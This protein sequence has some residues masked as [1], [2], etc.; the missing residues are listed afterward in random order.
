MKKF[1]ATLTLRNMIET[2]CRIISESFT[3]QGWRKPE[4]QYR[5]YL[6]QQKSSIRDVLIAEKEGQFCGYLTI[7]W[8]SDYPFFKEKGI[9]EIQDFNV[10]QHYQ[11]HGIG[12]ALMNEAEKRIKKISKYAGIGFGLTKDYGAAQILY[13]KRRYV[14]DGKGLVSH[15]KYA[16][17]GENVPV[18]DDLALY[19]IKQL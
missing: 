6:E 11:R 14:P 13:V 10:L 17:Y 3:K 4:S 2:D 12:T 1:T 9:P 5:Q 16:E 18:D 8:Q 19:L 15:S 7:N